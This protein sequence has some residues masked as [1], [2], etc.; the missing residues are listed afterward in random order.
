MIKKIIPLPMTKEFCDS[1][2]SNCNCDERFP[3]LITSTNDPNMSMILCNAC[4]DMALANANILP[5]DF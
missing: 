5:E 1:C 4:I 2:K 3:Y